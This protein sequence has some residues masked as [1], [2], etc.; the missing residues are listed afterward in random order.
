MNKILV[1]FD[2]SEGS[3]HALNRAMMLIYEFGEL[4][5]LAVVPSPDNKLF[6]DENSSKK[7][8]KKAKNLIDNTI[9]ELG[10]QSFTITGMIEQGDAA[11]TIIDISNRLNVDL[12]VLGSKG[13]SE[14]G[15]YLI[16]SVANKVV[17]YAA[18]PVMVV[19]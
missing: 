19:R 17:Q 15:R 8:K 18:K 5:L 11:A 12:I 4:I 6:V 14:L 13:Q 1:G 10:E 16:G 2:G 7:L 3:E 9:N